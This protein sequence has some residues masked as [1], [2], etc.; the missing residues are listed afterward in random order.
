MQN[1]LSDSDLLLGVLSVRVFFYLGL[2]KRLSSLPF[3]ASDFS[4]CEWS[5]ALDLPLGIQKVLFCSQLFTSKHGRAFVRTDYSCVSKNT[6]GLIPPSHI[7]GTHQG[8]EKK[9]Q[10]QPD[11]AKTS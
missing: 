5:S 2:S 8:S 4:P 10:K 1:E 7:S 6:S 9:K 3:F 11:L